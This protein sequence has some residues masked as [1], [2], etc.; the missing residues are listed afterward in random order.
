MTYWIF[1][2]TGQNEMTGYSF[3]P[4]QQIIMYEIITLILIATTIIAIIYI[5]P[6]LLKQE[7]LY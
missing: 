1:N 7:K 4:E 2:E 3:F 5:I 6:S